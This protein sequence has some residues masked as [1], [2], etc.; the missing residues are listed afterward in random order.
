MSTLTTTPAGDAFSHAFSFPSP[1]MRQTDVSALHRVSGGAAVLEPPA[2]NGLRLVADPTTTPDEGWTEA[3]SHVEAEGSPWSLKQKAL[4]AVWMTV[5]RPL[6]RATFHNWYAM[7]NSILRAFGAK[8]GPGARIRP[9]AKIEIPWNVEVGEKATI[10]DHAIIYSLGK[11]TIGARAIIS[12]YA[13]LCAGTHD[14]NDR[15]FR[16]LRTPVTVEEDAWVAADAYVGPGVT[17]GRLAVLG[18]RSN[19]FK[20][21]E[22]GWIYVGSP[23]RPTRRRNLR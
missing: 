5:G 15:S 8:I 1:A 21:L 20:S 19:A 14:V 2:A 13:H 17:V 9:T 4:R 11:I 16:L 12:Q 6:F 10:G 18:A 23:A 3:S 7:R 22:P